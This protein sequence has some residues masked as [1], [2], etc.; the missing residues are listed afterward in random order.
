MSNNRAPIKFLWVFGHAAN[1]PNKTKKKTNYK[2]NL[3]VETLFLYIGKLSL[4]YWV[5]V[6]EHIIYVDEQ[7]F[8]L[9]I[10]L[11]SLSSFVDQR[12]YLNFVAL[13]GRKSNQNIHNFNFEIVVDLKYVL[14][15]PDS[16][17]TDIEETLSV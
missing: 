4:S 15:S 7:A 16:F 17:Q 6:I 10:I 12:I 3:R 9:V 14:S 13:I 2:R 1:Q 8:L 11:F 5:G